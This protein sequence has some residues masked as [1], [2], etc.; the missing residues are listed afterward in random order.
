[1]NRRR[2]AALLAG[3]M[4]LGVP[5]VNSVNAAPAADR[6][7]LCHDLGQA[8]DQRHLLCVAVTR[9]SR[10]A[11]PNGLLVARSDDA[12]SHWA[13]GTASGVPVS[14]TTSLSQVLAAADFMSSHAWY[15][16]TS[17]TG[18]YKSTDGGATWALVDPLARQPSQYPSLTPLSISLPVGPPR[19]ALAFA[20]PSLGESALVDLPGRIPVAASPD[21]GLTFVWAS[22]PGPFQRT[23]AVA[24]YVDESA[25]QANHSRVYGCSALLSCTTLFWEAPA[26]Q[27]LQSV[28]T[29]LSFGAT[30]KVALV[31][32]EFANRRLHIYV[33]KDG[34]AHFAPLLGIQPAL[35]QLLKMKNAHPVLNAEI[36]Y[37]ATGGR[38]FARLVFQFGD[39]SVPREQ[40]WGSDSAGR[41]K[42]LAYSNFVRSSKTG[43]LP[44][45][46]SFLS[47]TYRVANLR[48]NDKGYLLVTA[49]DPT[50]A[51]YAG[52]FCSPDGLRWSRHC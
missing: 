42:R 3:L 50:G 43:S 28:S 2:A 11:A 33:S 4:L 7:A 1:M 34:G 37:A 13:H 45:F 15:L 14:V 23:L 19:P 46:G 20:S 25:P 32:Q 17:D 40:I 47:P 26:G 36:A 30:G 51:G 48:I 49:V 21:G 44:W 12:G 16:A 5:T 41:W 24:T 9:D 31:M 10:T 6:Q 18:V 27:V 35:D 39:G 22:S 8:P 29:D 52:F 38:M